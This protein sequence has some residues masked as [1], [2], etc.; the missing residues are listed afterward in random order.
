M[1][2]CS[3]SLQQHRLV[4]QVNDLERDE[5]YASWPRELQTLLMPMYPGGWAGGWLGGQGG[6]NW[7]P[8]AGSGVR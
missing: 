4:R 5:R 3:A 8:V 1:L 2:A 7:L 6:A